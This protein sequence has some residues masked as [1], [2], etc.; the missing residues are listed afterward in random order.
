V[1]RKRLALSLLANTI[2]FGL[3][4]GVA[5]V[6][7]PFLVASV[8]KDAYSFYPL[9][10]SIV[11][12]MEVLNTA[13]NS[14]AARFVMLALDREGAERANVYF[15]SILRSNLVLACLLAPLVLLFVTHVDSFLTVP[16][17]LLGEVQVLFAMVLGGALIRLVGS[18]FGIAVFVKDRLD[19]KAVID[20]ALSVVRVVVYVLLFSVLRP[21]VAYVGAS[22]IVVELVNLAANAAMTRRLAPELHFW[23][24]KFSLPAVSEVLSA[25]AWVSLRQLGAILLSYLALL[26]ANVYLGPGPSGD[27]GIASTATNFISGFI[28]VIGG[29]FV[30]ATTRLFAAGDTSLLVRGVVRAQE[31]SGALASVIVG[32]YIALAHDFFKLWVP[33]EDAGLLTMVSIL[34]V[35]MLPLTGATWPVSNLNVAMN[36]VRVP[37]FAM[38]TG[39]LASAVLS[40][41]SLSLTSWGVI[42]MAVASMIPTLFLL[43]V[44]VPLYP[45]RGLSISRTSFYLPLAKSVV[46]VALALAIT[47]GLR[48]VVTVGSWWQLGVVGLLAGG[49]GLAL[50]ALVMFGPRMA[51][52]EARAVLVRL[53]RMPG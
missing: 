45:C 49:F 26:L 53:R 19:L 28:G 46:M 24:Q 7:T 30:P 35:A 50:S 8:G 51:M 38:L 52:Q 47:V 13:L 16:A 42:G 31:I 9:A 4:A 1:G 14:M 6:L 33:G 44:F 25:G 22:V 18:S 39:G 3:S 11:L 29:L 48:A 21:S 34:T 41:L 15:S 10:M 12:Y 27:Y 43:V 40:Y 2:S 36:Q 37:A 23:R 17:D 32:V 20:I 5:L